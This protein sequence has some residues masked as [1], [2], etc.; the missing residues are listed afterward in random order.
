MHSWKRNPQTANKRRSGIVRNIFQY[1]TYVEQFEKV[2][3]IF[4]LKVEIFLRI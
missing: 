3:T 1:E 2:P 4:I